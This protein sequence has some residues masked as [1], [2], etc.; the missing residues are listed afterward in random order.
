MARE[1]RILG[2]NRFEK[3]AVGARLKLKVRVADA[4]APSNGAPVYFE[5]LRP[6]LVEFGT[7][8]D[9]NSD[10]I[11]SH[12]DG[13]AEAWVTLKPGSAGLALQVKAQIFTGN[14]GDTD[15]VWFSI[16]VNP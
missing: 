14:D 8:A 1:L 10:V 7:M 4:G 2:P 15:T 5:A 3:V 13:T 11:H 12:D 6:D 16:A 9:S